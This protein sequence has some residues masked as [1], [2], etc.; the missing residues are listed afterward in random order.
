[1]PTWVS[2]RMRFH[3][4]TLRMLIRIF[5]LCACSVPTI[6]DYRA[7]RMIR[8]KIS[9]LEHVICRHITP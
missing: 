3:I 5:A 9:H 4:L 6:L 2:A 1:M 7:S 8:Q